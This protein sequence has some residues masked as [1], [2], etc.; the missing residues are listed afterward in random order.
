MDILKQ[1]EKENPEISQT[2]ASSKFQ[3]GGFLIRMVMR[4]S[5]GR[6]GDVASA[7]FILV[8]IIIFFL[9]ISVY[10]FYKSSGNQRTPS[11]EEMRKILQ[12]LNGY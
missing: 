10:F 2:P 12:Q 5:G 9:I 6:V 3:E 8:G 11:R 7:N 1:Y 4:L